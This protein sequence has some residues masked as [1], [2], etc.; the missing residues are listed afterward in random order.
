MPQ[1]QLLFV[2]KNLNCDHQLIG[3]DTET[4]LTD[5]WLTVK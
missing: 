1:T 5:D 4:Q 2:H 3:D